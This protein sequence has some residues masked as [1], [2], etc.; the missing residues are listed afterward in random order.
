MSVIKTF[1]DIDSRT[2][3]RYRADPCAFI[4]E[5]LISPYDGQP[6][7]LIDAERRF[8]K[9][10][11]R[12][13]EDGRLV[14]PLMLYGAIKKTRKTE[15]A[16]L[17]TL[18]V[19]LL[20]GGRF[21]QGFI[22]ANDEQ[23]AIARCFTACC[24]I[25]EASPLL[26][27]EAIIM[28]DKI[29]FPATQ[30][31]ITAIANDYTGI[32]GG[33]PTISVFDELW[34]AT[35]E[36]SRRLFDELI[37]VP[38]RKVSC[39]LVTTHAGFEDE[40]A[41]LLELYERG[42]A[43]P[44]VGPD[45]HAGDGMLF[46]WSHVPLHH[47]QDEKWL[48]QMR[49][50]LRLNQYLRMIENRFTS[51]EAAFIDMAEW[52]K[53]VDP[54][55]G[56]IA[57]NKDRVVWIGIDASVK[58]DSTA[59]VVVSWERETNKVRLVFHRIFQPNVKEPLDFEATVERTVREL[60]QRFVVKKVLYDPF[61]MAA[62]SQRL[63]KAGVPMREC[64]QTPENLTAFGTNLYELIKGGNL[65]AYPDNAISLAISHAIAKETPRGWK[66]AKEKS[67]HKIDFVVAL[68]MAAYA[69]V[70]RPYE[71][72]IPLAVAQWNMRTGEI[73]APAAAAD[74]STTSQYLRW[75]NS[76]AWSPPGGWT[77][78]RW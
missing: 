72:D 55:Y 46:F 59:I 15:L 71:Q 12:F 30:S 2:L 67:S 13:D 24:R 26:K 1:D 48:A 63:R 69:A 11:F 61:Q 36:R 14:H 34:G 17:L 68:A 16:G 8:I 5:C 23:Q 51:N 20:F 54:N 44:E 73:T 45:L 50:E 38:T 66:I 27:R 60:C 6:Y 7:R 19:I 31:S 70:Q 78:A 49:R 25:V 40:G 42:M 47:W 58:R 33:H 10:A 43:L 28:A 37:P 56:P 39:R 64:K 18:T 29:G 76:G 41:L 65:I 53:C 62:V 74:E 75:A 4:E 9:L 35:S 3:A 52:R 32:A 57:A 21:A 22:V 77:P